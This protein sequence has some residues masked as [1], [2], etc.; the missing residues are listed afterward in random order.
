MRG[1]RA[2]GI[3]LAVAAA[4]WCL[5]AGLQFAAAQPKE[6]PSA[7]LRAALREATV[8][9]R[10]LEDQNATLLAKQ[11]AI[12]RDQTNF[13]QKAAQG[14]KALQA[15]RA[16]SRSAESSLQ[17][18]LDDQKAKQ[19]K[20]EAAYREAAETARTRD[21]DAKRFEAA[22]TALREQNRLAEEKNTTLYKLGQELLELY[23]NKHVLDVVGAG[24]P[25]TKLKRVEYENVVQ[26]Y[27]DKLRASH[28]VHPAA[29]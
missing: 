28:I 18:E 25:V 5:L 12:D 19:A 17:K 13:S 15:L 29:Q 2:V 14:E 16:Q 27:D 22:L 21:A 8:R 6:D 20:W 9:V 26:G 7:R 1:S 4:V 10:E 23:D 24:E 3:S 11:S